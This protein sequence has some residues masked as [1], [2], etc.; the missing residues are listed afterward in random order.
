MKDKISICSECSGI[1]IDKLEKTFGKENIDYR[2]IG[3]CGGR[4]GIVIGFTKKT[5]I[6]AE[7]DEEFIRKIKE[8]R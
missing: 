6:E 5:L 2:C 4:E 1:D 7:S 8:L 3:E